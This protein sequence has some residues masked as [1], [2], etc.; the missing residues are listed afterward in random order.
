MLPMFSSWFA[1]F[2]ILKNLKSHLHLKCMSVH[3]PT[4]VVCIFFLRCL[5]LFC[6][7]CL[8]SVTFMFHQPPHLALNEGDIKCLRTDCDNFYLFLWKIHTSS[9]LPLPTQ[10]FAG[11]HICEWDGF[12]RVHVR[13]VSR[14]LWGF[15]QQDVVRLADKDSS[16][17]VGRKE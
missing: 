6:I 10:N 13:Q 1:S 12:R 4:H 11:R 16:F 8:L 3:L 15:V 17:C 5:F 2:L 9:P 14:V 7:L